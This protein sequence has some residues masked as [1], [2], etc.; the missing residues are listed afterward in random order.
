MNAK[1][2]VEFWGNFSDLF[3]DIQ[4]SP[5]MITGEIRVKNGS[6]VQGKIIGSR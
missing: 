1:K 5:P 6:K 4:T 2:M 3:I